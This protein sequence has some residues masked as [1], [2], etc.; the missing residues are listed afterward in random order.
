[1]NLPPA[2]VDRGQGWIIQKI[3]KIDQASHTA[4]GAEYNLIFEGHDALVFERL[5]PARE[6]AKEAPP[7]HAPVET[8]AEPIDDA[9]DTEAPV[10]AEAGAEHEPGEAQE[11][12][13]VAEAEHGETQDS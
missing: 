11:S 4:L 2:V 8:V 3:G 12:G 1:M 5:G 9:A 7:E 6:R 10:S 13:D